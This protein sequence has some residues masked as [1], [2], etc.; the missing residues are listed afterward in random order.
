MHDT[1][2]QSLALILAFSRACREELSDDH[3]TAL[4]HLG[5]IIDLSKESLDDMRRMIADS[6]PA[7]LETNDLAEAIRRMVDKMKERKGLAVSLEIAPQLSLLS[8]QTQVNL[9]RIVQEL[10]ANVAAHAHAPQV[11]LSLVMASGELVL[12]ISDNGVGF[13]TSK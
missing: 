4:R 5:M 2:V 1:I 9:L 12:T 13:D 7:N 6:S 10:L 3:D 11:S 8:K